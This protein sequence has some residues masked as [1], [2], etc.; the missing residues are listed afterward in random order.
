MPTQLQEHRRKQR[1]FTLIEVLVATTV[2]LAG[3]VAVAQLVPASLTANSANRSDSTA[4]VF[5]QRELAQIMDQP[6]ALPSFIDVLGNTCN[7]GNS[8]APNTVVGSPVVVIN[9]RP[10][11]DFSAAR[12]AGYNFNYKDPQDP[13]FTTY[14]VRWAVITSVNGTTVTSKRYI[15]G[16]RKSGGNGYFQAVTLDSVVAK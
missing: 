7:L 10:T 15:I 9:N 8:A 6:L 2:L 4:L 5:A 3:I 16:T 14:D 1:G 12:V 11:I 13:F